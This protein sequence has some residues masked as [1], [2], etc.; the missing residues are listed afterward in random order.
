MHE[1]FV[2]SYKKAFFR[3]Q[4]LASD[5]CLSRSLFHKS[6]YILRLLY[7]PPFSAEQI[8]A[9]LYVSILHGGLKKEDSFFEFA[10]QQNLFF[11]EAAWRTRVKQVQIKFK[12]K[13]K[14]LENFVSSPERLYQRGTE[15]K[16]TPREIL[17]WLEM[18]DIVT[19][20]TR[21]KLPVSKTIAF[22]LYSSPQKKLERLRRWHSMNSLGWVV[23]QPLLDQL[24]YQTHIPFFEKVVCHNY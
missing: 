3:L 16:K 14:K 24:K 8:G 12:K 6:L 7:N 13:K 4:R 20:V 10:F 5:L 1:H 17:V 22:V 11:N 21:N 18:L 9:I 23:T 2:F 15:K 19:V